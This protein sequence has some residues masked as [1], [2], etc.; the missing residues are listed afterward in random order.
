MRPSSRVMYPDSPLREHTP[1]PGHRPRE[2]CTAE[3]KKYGL[4]IDYRGVS[5]ELQ[6]ALLAIFAPSG[7]QRSFDAR[8]RRAAPAL[9][10]QPRGGPCGSRDGERQGRSSR[11]RGR[12]RVRRT[13]ASSGSLVIA[14][15]KFAQSLDMLSSDPRSR[16]WAMRA[17][18]ARSG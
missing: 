2:P 3:G 13:C 6:E 16:T 4:I 17:G 14:F 8:W 10:T 12:A 11:L 5:E 9:Q 1:A 7:H 15:K 18:S